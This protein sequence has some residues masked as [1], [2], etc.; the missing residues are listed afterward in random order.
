MKRQTGPLATCIRQ[1]A[2]LYG[3]G[4]PDERRVFPV[5]CFL[6][7]KLLTDLYLI[8]GEATEMTLQRL[9]EAVSVQGRISSSPLGQQPAIL[10]Y[11]ETGQE[12]SSM[13]AGPSARSPLWEKLS[14]RCSYTAPTRSLRRC[15]SSDSLLAGRSMGVFTRGVPP[16]LCSSF[17]SFPK[18][19]EARMRGTA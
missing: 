18:R 10:E 11:D 5:R 3:S 19:R 1:A 13:T 9:G 4:K 16:V 12:H 8:P 14:L 2:D 17:P 7:G 15:S 6:Q